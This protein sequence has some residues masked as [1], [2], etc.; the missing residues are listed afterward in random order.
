[1][2]GNAAKNRNQEF[3]WKVVPIVNPDGL[4]ARKRVNAPWHR[5]E[6]QFSDT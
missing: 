1:M 4:L 6:S 2:D 3:Q 5:F